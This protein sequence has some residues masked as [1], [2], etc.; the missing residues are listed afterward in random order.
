MPNRAWPIIDFAEVAGV[1]DQLH[2]NEESADCKDLVFSNSMPRLSTDGV[3][4]WLAT[5]LEIFYAVVRRSVAKS[6]KIYCRVAAPFC[7][8]A[9]PSLGAELHFCSMEYNLD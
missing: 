8:A 2:R 3:R 4:S 9:T 1:V 6:V 7:T 5:V